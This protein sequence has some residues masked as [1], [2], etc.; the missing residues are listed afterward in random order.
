MACS[1]EQAVA[2]FSL[3]EIQCL[4]SPL[5]STRIFLNGGA[6]KKYHEIFTRKPWLEKPAA[7]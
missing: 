3:T 7:L 1:R 2:P 4:Y 6:L 5:N